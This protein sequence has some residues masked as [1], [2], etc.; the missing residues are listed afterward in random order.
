MVDPMVMQGE[1]SMYF[2]LV[3][4]D[5]KYHGTLKG[6]WMLFDSI[7]RTVQSFAEDGI[8]FNEV[9][10]KA[11]T[12]E[13]LS[14]CTHFK[15]S[16]IAKGSGDGVWAGRLPDYILQPE[17]RRSHPRLAKLYAQHFGS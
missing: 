15:L 14:L 7:T 2:V 3:V 5:P 10:A 9:C 11:L 17:M 1:Y 8:F 4:S 6:G 16:Q 12:P 13:G